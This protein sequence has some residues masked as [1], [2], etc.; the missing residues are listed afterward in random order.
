MNRLEA[1]ATV[2]EV[3]KSGSLSAAGR[4]LHMPLAT[5]SR[6]VSDLEAHL[7]AQIFTRTSRKLALTE[8][9]QAYVAACQRILDDLTEAERA[10]SGEYRAP[11]GELVLTAPVVFGRMHVLPLAVDFLKAHPEIDLR[12]VFTDH[13]LN[14]AEEHIDLAVRIGRLPDS[15]MH[16]RLAG[17]TRRVVCAS[18]AYLAARGVPM[19][20]EDLAD[21]DAISL[22]SLAGGRGWTFGA[23]RD[24]VV[25]PV[26]TRLRVNASEAAIDAAIAGIG[27]VRLLSYQIAEPCRKG[28]L[29]IVLEDFEPEPWPVH[30]VHL[31]QGPLPLKV[32]AFLDW[33]G[34]RLKARLAA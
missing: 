5:I 4:R 32:R 24:E 8:A 9:G 29:R 11:K 7:G 25:A 30:L 23:G 12:M 21:H 27:L 22:D 6:K 18:P 26:H 20:P 13:T 1:M 17:H 31:A 33:A 2:L 28:D 10:M 3:V 16:A 34:P 14:L 19:R 15:Q